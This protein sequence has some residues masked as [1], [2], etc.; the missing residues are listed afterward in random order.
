MLILFIVVAFVVGLAIGTFAGPTL[1]KLLAEAIT[2]VRADA[3][4]AVADAQALA[5]KVKADTDIV[6][7][8]VQA[9]AAK[10]KSDAE[11]VVADAKNET[12]KAKTA[13]LTFIDSVQNG[14]KPLTLFVNA[15]V[16]AAAIGAAPPA[17]KV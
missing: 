11:V 2:D 13:L 5:V 15:P 9:D 4:K 16:A 17:I 3:A 6:I 8:G 1:R 14:D 7:A 10:V 12:I